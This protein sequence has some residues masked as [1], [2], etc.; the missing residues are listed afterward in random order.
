MT[1]FTQDPSARLDYTVDW[2]AELGTDTIATSTWVVAD[3]LTA[4]AQ[5]NTTTTASVFVSGGTA[6][7]SY[8]L[9]NTI[10]TAGG[11]IDTRHIQL[12]V[13]TR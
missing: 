12:N 7:V 9:A 3:G 4:S 13:A 1:L 2:S 8:I 10:T 5:S 11:R 6:G